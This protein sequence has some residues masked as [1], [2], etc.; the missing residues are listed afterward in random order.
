MLVKDL[1]TIHERPHFRT[2]VYG[3]SMT[4]SGRSVAHEPL[5]LTFDLVHEGMLVRRT[6]CFHELAEPLRSLATGKNY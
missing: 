2:G 3:I 1:Q 5:A 4:R 6:R